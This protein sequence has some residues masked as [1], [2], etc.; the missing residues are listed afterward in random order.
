MRI[1]LAEGSLGQVTTKTENKNETR[2]APG[3]LY[4]A[5]VVPPPRVQNMLRSLKI[6]ALTCVAEDTMSICLAERK[7][8]VWG[9]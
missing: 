9:K 2:K 7:L 1:C 3:A 8:E 5:V 4:P 6:R